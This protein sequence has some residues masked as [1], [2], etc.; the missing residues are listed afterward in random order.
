MKKV[1]VLI[2]LVFSS[3]SFS[4]SGV[5]PELKKEITKKVI[6]DLSKVNLNDNNNDYVM[7]SFIIENEEIIIT[8]IESS[9]NELT[10]IMKKELNQIRIDSEYEE[11]VTYKYRFT[12][13]KK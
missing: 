2:V 13:T 12:F 9:M 11:G 4:F 5:N 1:A 3:M 6:V 8:N 7:V 10:E